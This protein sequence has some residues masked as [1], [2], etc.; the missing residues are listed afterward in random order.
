[1]R[2]LRP[3]LR[4]WTAWGLEAAVLASGPALLVWFNRARARAEA[5]ADLVLLVARGTAA[6]LLCQAA[7]DLVLEIW[8]PA[9]WLGVGLAVSLAARRLNDLALGIVAAFVAL[10]AIGEAFWLTPDLSQS[11]VRGLG[12]DPVLATSLPSAMD[13][14]ALLAIPAA[15]LAA[16]RLALP[17]PPLGA[18]RATAIIAGL[19]AVAAAHVWFKQVPSARR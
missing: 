8:A 11:L 2:G 10:V 9:A 3:E 18:R 12:G 6:F 15:L 5:P 14:L 17:P 4:G 7:W 19:F 1:M 13:A 16:M